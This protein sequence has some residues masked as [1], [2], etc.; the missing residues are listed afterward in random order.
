MTKYNYRYCV[1]FNNCGV[2]VQFVKAFNS[3]IDAL[4]HKEDLQRRAGCCDVVKKRFLPG[5]NKPINPYIYN[6]CK[7]CSYDL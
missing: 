1:Y 2:G 5:E 7:Y 6:N 4:N 3:L